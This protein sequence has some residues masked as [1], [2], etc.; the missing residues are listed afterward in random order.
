MNSF[1]LCLD[2]DGLGH[3][4][5]ALGGVVLEGANHGSCAGLG[6]ANLVVALTILDLPGHLHVLPR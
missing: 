5:G 2:V 6:E 4:L 3:R 1:E